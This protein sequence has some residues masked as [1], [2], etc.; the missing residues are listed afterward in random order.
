MALVTGS[1]GGS[2]IIT[3]VLQS[4]LGIVDYGLNAQQA[5]TAPR[6]HHQWLPDQIDVEAGALLPAAQDTLRA[7]GYHLT[8]RLPWGRLDI[9]QVLP[10]GTPGR[11]RRPARRR[12]GAGVLGLIKH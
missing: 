9:I 11:R 6:L 7:R 10:D 1:P 8:P 2:T 12:Y 4:I 3:S 5:V